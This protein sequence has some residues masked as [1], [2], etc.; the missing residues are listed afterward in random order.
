[1]N[2][3]FEASKEVQRQLNVKVKLERNMTEEILEIFQVAKSKFNK[4]ELTIDEITIAYYNMFTESNKAPIRNKKAISMKLF[5][6]KGGTKDN[7][8]L[9]AVGK[10]VYRIRKQPQNTEE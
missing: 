6:M 9:E 5:L 1:M 10:G 8:I 4:T 2:N 7:G 3:I